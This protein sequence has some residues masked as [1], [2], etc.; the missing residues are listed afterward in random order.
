MRKTKIVCTMGPATEDRKV[1]EQLMLAGMSVARQN[2]SHGTHETHKAM[3]D[4]VVDVARILGLP[5]A[6][7]MDTKGP[8]VRLGDFEGGKVELKDGDYF[9]LTTDEVL[10][11]DVR[12]SV[13]YSGLPADV[14]MGTTILIDDGNV[15]LRVED[16]TVTDLTCKVIHGGMISNHKGINVPNVKLSMP[17]VSSVDDSDIRFAAREGF[18]F[19]AASFVTCAEDVYAVRKILQEEGRPDIQI[20][21]KIE[22]REGVNKMNEIIEAADGIMVAR[23]DMGVEIPFAEIPRI[24]KE[25]LYKCSL[26]SKPAITATQMLE[27]MMHHARPTRAEI[28]DVANAVYDGSD[29]IMLSGETAAGEYPVEAVRAMASIAETAE[30]GINYDER[31]RTYW[32]QEQMDIS[33]A[34]SHS[35]VSAAID[36][37]AKAVFALTKSGNTARNIAKYRPSCEIIAC[38][39][40]EVTW[41]QLALAWGTTPRLTSECKNFFASAEL[42]VKTAIRDAY[43]AELVGSDDIVV[44]TA[45]VPLGV[46][47]TTNLMKI[48]N[49]ALEV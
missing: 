1:L 12:A 36:I 13:T 21:A 34:I 38:T 24:Q 17:Y 25:I 3:H 20:I 43:S 19:I 45:G 39:Y 30:Q 37:G 48:C 49:V 33:T 6:T 4:N 44:A 32:G 9:N 14:E 23:G 18:D 46:S 22:N 26:V 29:A 47:G 35:A 2:F 16:K 28:S 11:T 5:V 27:S 41:R 31:F 40:S 42:L 15:E 8:E 10:G 7:M